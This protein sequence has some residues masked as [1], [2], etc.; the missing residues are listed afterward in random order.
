M[1]APHVTILWRWR[2]LLAAGLA[3]GVA[4]SAAAQMP[5]ASTFFQQNCAACHTIGGGA[6][7][8]P[9]LKGATER[10]ERAWLIRFIENPKAVVDA[11]DPAAKAMVDAAGGLVMPQIAGMTPQMAEALVDMI[12][13]GASQAPAGPSVTDRAFT[14]A[15]VEHGRR[16]FNGTERLQN[17]GPACLACHN[18][19]AGEGMGGGRLGPD[20]TTVYDR[21]KGRKALGM[22]LSAPATTTMRSLFAARAFTPEEIEALL[23]YFEDAATRPASPSGPSLAFLAAGSVGAIAGLVLFAFHWRGRLRAVRRRLVETATSGGTR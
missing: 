12:A 15:D 9:D 20:L 8:G 23:A 4:H 2:A 1:T 5:P 7:V 17:G 19:G 6:L 21:L 10:H 18:A 14:A 11:G 3:L 16:L 13:G 22:W